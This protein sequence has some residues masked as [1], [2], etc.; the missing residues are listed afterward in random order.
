MNIVELIRH[1]ENP[2]KSIPM[3][4]V[5]NAVINE[6]DKNKATRI[7]RRDKINLQK[8]SHV[9]YTLIDEQEKRKCQE[10]I[11][12]ILSIYSVGENLSCDIETELSKLTRI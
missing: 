12:D 10:K 5:V 9:F 4:I 7:I 2:G 6:L 11:A 3:I 1:I 8:L